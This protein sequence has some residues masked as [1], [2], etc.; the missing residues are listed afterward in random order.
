MRKSIIIIFIGAVL[1]GVIVCGVSF[2]RALESAKAQAVQ[3]AQ[4]AEQAQKA[5]QAEDIRN[6]A[7]HEGDHYLNLAV[8]QDNPEQAK[9]YYTLAGEQYTV[10]LQYGGTDS[11]A[12]KKLDICKQES[13]QK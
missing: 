2:K 3:Q 13:G 11:E 7:I 4:Q 5:K 10:Y 1:A 6:M 8:N 12:Q 9:Y